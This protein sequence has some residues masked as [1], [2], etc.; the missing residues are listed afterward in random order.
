M[1]SIPGIDPKL[2]VTTGSYQ[3]AKIS[4]ASVALSFSLPPRLAIYPVGHCLYD[5]CDETTNREQNANARIDSAFNPRHI[6][7]MI[8]S[9]D[10]QTIGQIRDDAK[11]P[12]N[13]KCLEAI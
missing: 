1:Q 13:S 4:R 8:E 12:A 10:D 6:G 5:R 2:T 9:R 11:A 7:R 3:E